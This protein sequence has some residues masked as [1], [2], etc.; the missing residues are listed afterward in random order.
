MTAEEL[1]R[2]ISDERAAFADRRAAAESLAQIGDPRGTAVDRVPI[3]AGR[4]LP[5]FAID[6]YPVTVALYG[7]FVAASG[8]QER[9]FW[10]DEG[11][12]W[13][14][15][16]S[17]TLPRFWGDPA[18]AAY[19]VANHPVVGVSFHEAQ[20]YA[21][22]R[23]ARLPTEAEWEHAARGDDGRTYPWGNEWID[24]ACGRR[25]LGP[26]GTLP[27]GIFPRGQSP[28]GLQDVVGAVWQ[29]CTDLHPNPDGGLA[30][31]TR[32]GGWNNLPWS[33]TCTSVNPYPAGARHSNVGLRT[34][35]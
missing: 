32:G 21:T 6:R 15:A 29:W 16:E 27:I 23:G 2:V 10:S 28:F 11:W 13:K 24:D 33:L 31:A 4:G 34:V 19:L 3:P 1:L 22:F 14:L 12:A 17:V 30:R 7:E 9:R 18:W 25:D 20:A 8:Y 5:G 26:R 35:V